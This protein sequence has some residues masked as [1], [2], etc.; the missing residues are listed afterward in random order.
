MK[1]NPA[2]TGG[3]KDHKGEMEFENIPLGILRLPCIFRDVT[4]KV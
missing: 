1:M 4:D 2:V 3:E